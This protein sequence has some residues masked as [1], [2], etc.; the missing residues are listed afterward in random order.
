VSSDTQE[1]TLNSWIDEAITTAIERVDAIAA[2]V[3]DFPHITER[4]EWS[5]TPDGVWTGGFWTG[6]LWLAY[7]RTPTEDRAKLARRFTERLLPRAMDTHNHD[8]G[9]MFFPSAVKGWQLTGEERY[10]QAA[11]TAARSLASQFNERGGFIPGWGFFGGEDW[12]G[13]V[14]IDTLMNLPLLVWALQQGG[15]AD[16]MDVVRRHTDTAL[17]NHLRA[18]GSVAHVFKFDATNGR[19]LAP[20]TYQGLS[21]DSAWARG[22]AWALTGLALLARMTGEQKYRAASERIAARFVSSLPDDLVPP[23]DFSA[24]GR[25]EPRDSSAAAIA[26]F[27]LL[28]LSEATGD[29]RHRE[30]ASRLLET[31]A[32][33]CAN[34]TGQGGLLL[35][36][37]ADLPH[38]LGINES[39]MYGDFY[40]L[41]ALLTID[42]FTISTS[43]YKG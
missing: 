38:G 33:T 20:A 32:A 25:D 22:Q 23:W 29:P 5:C 9:F 18:D 16:L 31:L 37:T 39:T 15:P 6:L 17:A 34:R 35:H 43:S 27:G 19:P 42:K 13:S 21:A 7:E 24:T 26:S 30:T 3:T 12:S 4:G 1:T 10:R 11:M 14:L 28:K 41:K 8:L 2:S 40:Y 36:A